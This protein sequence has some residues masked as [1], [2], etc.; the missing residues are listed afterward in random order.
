VYPSSFFFHFLCSPYR[1]R[2]KYAIIS[3][4]NF[5]LFFLLRTEPN[6]FAVGYQCVIVCCSCS[7]VLICLTMLILFIFHILFFFFCLAVE[8]DLRFFFPISVKN[9]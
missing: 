5:L 2:G 6:P 3:F 9:Q 1:I 4:Q 7:H 8:P